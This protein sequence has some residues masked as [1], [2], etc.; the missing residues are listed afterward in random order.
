[1]LTLAIGEKVLVD[2]LSTIVRVQSEER[3]GQ[4]LPTLSC[5]FPHTPTHSDHPV[6]ISTVD[7]VYR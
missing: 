6:A 3:E 1:L 2:E 5:P 4:S 7:R